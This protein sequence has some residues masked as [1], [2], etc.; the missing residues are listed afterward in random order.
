MAVKRRAR[1]LGGSV[2]KFAVLN[3]VARMDPSREANDFLRDVRVSSRARGRAP[4][5]DD[6]NGT[7]TSQE[8][9]Q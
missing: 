9:Q 8:S 6:E 2:R 4:R 1:S 3:V 5:G 7:E